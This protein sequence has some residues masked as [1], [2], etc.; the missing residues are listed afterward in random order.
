MCDGLEHDFER[1]DIRRYDQ[2]KGTALL[3]RAKACGGC[4]LGAW[5][6]SPLLEPVLR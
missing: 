3:Q 6:R 1:G 2:Q 4:V 5:F